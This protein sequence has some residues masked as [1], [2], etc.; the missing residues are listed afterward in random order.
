MNQ[1]IDYIMIAKKWGEIYKHPSTE[2]YYTVM[3]TNDTGLL[4]PT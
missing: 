3:K 4:T 2:D 1:V